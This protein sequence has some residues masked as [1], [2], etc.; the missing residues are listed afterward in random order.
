MADAKICDR[1]SKF[2]ITNELEFIGC[3]LRH[4]EHSTQSIY[5]DLCDE[6]VRKLSN[7]LNFP[8]ETDDA[9]DRYNQTKENGKSKDS[10]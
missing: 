1:C 5:F 4:R 10:V 9:I 6:C 7:F 2:Y 8:V 3:S